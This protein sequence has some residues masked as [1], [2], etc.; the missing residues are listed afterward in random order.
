MLFTA[1]VHWHVSQLGF[2]QDKEKNAFQTTLE[3]I[4]CCILLKV[5]DWQKQCMRGKERR[6][7][8]GEDN[9]TS[10]RDG[11]K[12]IYSSKMNSF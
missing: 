5:G 4:A 2:R 11:P 7:G 8:D 10:E 1:S 3:T 12:Q 9:V 6:G